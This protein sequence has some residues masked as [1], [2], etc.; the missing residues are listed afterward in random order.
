[1]KRSVVRAAV[2]IG[3]LA[4]VA[5]PLEAQGYNIRLGAWYQS[6]AYRGWQSDTIPVADAVPGT[7]GGFVTSDG[8][9]ASC[10]STICTFYRPGA[11]LRGQPLVATVDAGVWGFGVPGLQ[12]RIRTRL[13]ADLADAVDL[14]A[15]NADLDVWPA[16][17]PNLQLVEGYLE[18]STRLYTVQAGRTHV[19]S[20]L[21]FVGLDGGQVTARP[22]SGKLRVGAWGGWALANAT[23]L[24]IT[25]IEVNPL[26]EFRPDVRPLVFGGQVGWRLPYV[27][28]RVVYQTEIDTDLDKQVGERGALDLT[29]RPPLDGLT[30]LGGIEYNFGIGEIGTHDIQVRYRDPSGWGQVTL[31]QKRYLPYFPLYSIWA[32]FSPLPYNSWWGSAA[33]YPLDGLELHARGE[34]YTYSDADESASPLAPLEDSGWRWSAGATFVTPYDITIGADYH[35]EFGPG[36]SSHGWYGRG[37]YTSPQFPF[38]VT[39]HGGYLLRPLE[40]RF[41]DTKV[42]TFGLRG[43]VELRDQLFLNV[44]AIRYDETRE[45]LD[46]A[47]FDWAH[48]RLNI[49]LTVLL[50]SS[51]ATRGLH[52]AILRIPETRRTR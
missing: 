31:G 10:G 12:A 17:E 1:M 45:R 29:F 2:A 6:V 13:G 21:G 37:I 25:R 24:P 23:T 42:W 26:G 22:L 19:F 34:T 41:N 36:A 51:G 4:A 30:V 9:A 35:A 50:S 49:G 27:E 43:D 3:V 46:A 47:A 48:T 7:G 15:P 16:V 5:T 33:F 11:E 20:R 28:G 14:S 32:V 18:Y 44:E 8:I 39:A 38:S 40:Y 52:P